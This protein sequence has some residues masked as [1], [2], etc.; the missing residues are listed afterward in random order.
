MVVTYHK[1]LTTILNPK[2]IIHPLAAAQLQRWT[3]TLSTHMYNIEF[4]FITAHANAD[5]FSH[6]PLKCAPPDNPHADAR[7]FNISQMEALPVTTHRLRSASLS[8]KLLSKAIRYTQGNWP[9]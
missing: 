5:E 3:W 7:V 4:R 8:D 2:K 1:P 9:V 6:L